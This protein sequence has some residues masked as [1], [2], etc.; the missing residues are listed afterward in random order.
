MSPLIPTYSVREP[1]PF[2][3]D[4][5]GWISLQGRVSLILFR[6]PAALCLMLHS[7]P[8][9]RFS[10]CWAH[11]ISTPPNTTDFLATAVLSPLLGSLGGQ[12][13]GQAD[14]SRPQL[15]RLTGSPQPCTGQ[16]G[17]SSGTGHLGCLSSRQLGCTV[18]EEQKRPALEGNPW[19]P[20]GPTPFISQM[21]MLRTEAAAQARRPVSASLAWG[22]AFEM[23]VES[24]GPCCVHVGP[25]PGE[26]SLL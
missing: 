17:P 11:F 25:T 16:L 9:G 4:V 5:P 10:P 14:G 6:P 23:L 21:R 13:G 22:Q 15:R 8:Q 24:P 19:S 1:T 26:S 7:L 12:E 20:P 2:S 18:L 3:T